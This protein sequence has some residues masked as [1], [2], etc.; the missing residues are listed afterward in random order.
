VRQP[1]GPRPVVQPP[2]RA[3]QRHRQVVGGVPGRRPR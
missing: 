1:L 3:G 2:G